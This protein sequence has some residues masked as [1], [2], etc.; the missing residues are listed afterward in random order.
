M[1]KIPGQ[2]EPEISVS[3]FQPLKNLQFLFMIH[4]WYTR[5]FVWPASIETL[6]MDETNITNLDITGIQKLSVLS[7]SATGLRDVPAIHQLAPLTSFRAQSNPLDVLS[8]ESI[9]R[10]CLL[11]NLVLDVTLISPTSSNFC[12]CSR[13]EK[14]VSMQ[15][16]TLDGTI[17]CDKPSG[18][19]KKIKRLFSKQISLHVYTWF[20]KD[21]I[22]C[23]SDFAEAI[24]ER[25]TCLINHGKLEPSYIYRIM[26]IG[27]V[28]L[29]GS[30][31]L[32][33]SFLTYRYFYKKSE[34]SEP[35]VPSGEFL[36]FGKFLN[37]FVY[38]FIVRSVLFLQKKLWRKKSP[39]R[40]KKNENSVF[41]YFFD[42][43]LI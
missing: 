11:E 29:I 8:A 40:T 15:N 17:E 5:N 42:N 26:L 22:T 20:F 43:V 2:S 19:W 32:V 6:V 1:S 25:D 41:A 12:R 39:R 33:I 30:M 28:L 23:S 3:T 13:L 24:D 21:P 10:Y 35:E 16:I 31:L 37:Q 34:T 18:S 14:W 9:A 4:S 7:L 36:L 38:W 27:G